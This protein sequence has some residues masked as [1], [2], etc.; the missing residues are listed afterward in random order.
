MS[1]FWIKWEKGL[2]RKP[3][4]LQLA[5]RLMVPPIQ[6]AGALMLVMEWLDDNVSDFDDDG[7]ARLELGAMQPSFL[8]GIVGISGFAEALAEVEWLRQDGQTLVF[9]N[10]GKHNGIT[11]KNRADAALRKRISRENNPVTDSRDNLPRPTRRAVFER[12]R[13]TCVYCNKSSTVMRER[14][15]RRALLSIDHIVPVTRGGGHNIE[16]LATAC[17]KCNQTKT[18]RL[19]EEAG[20]T[21]EFL[22]KGLVCSENKVTYLS[23]QSVTD[24][25]HLCSVSESALPSVSK[26]EAIYQAYPRKQGRK[27]ALKAIAKALSS[28]SFEEPPRD[29]AWLLGRVQAYAAAVALWPAGDERFIPHP[30]TWFNKGN[31]DDDPTTWVRTTADTGAKIYKAPFA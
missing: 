10:A 9:V 2:T 29:H 4:V 19:P 3:E 8:D 7:D 26:E 5:A 11:A 13:Y 24:L 31:Y 21:L 14:N 15:T 12:D 23:Q 25:G 17:R 16:N 28:L 22:Q 6:A 18:N 30:A 1:G 27:E 20:M